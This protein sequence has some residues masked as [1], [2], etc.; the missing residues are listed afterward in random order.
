M[1]LEYRPY[2]CNVCGHK[3]K[4]QTNHEGPVLNYCKEC[5]WKRDFKGKEHSHSI[6]ALSGHTY[7][8][9]TFDGSVNEMKAPNTKPNTIDIQ[10]FIKAKECLNEEGKKKLLRALRLY[11]ELQDPVTEDAMDRPERNVV[12]KTFDTKADFDSYVNQRRGIEMTSKEQQAILNYREAKPTQRDRFFVKFE[13]TDD[14]GNNDTTVIKKLKEGNQFCWTAFS[15][16]ETAEEEGKP[17]GSDEE[18]SLDEAAPMAPAQA[19]PTTPSNVPQPPPE[20]AEDEEMTVDDPIRITKTIT[21]TDDTE[22]S[23]VLADFL[24]K[25]DL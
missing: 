18:P 8:V 17:E 20:P 19:T 25:L 15:K 4:I 11:K 2:V 12:A 13:T 7:R 1:K 6:P 9:F 3:D 23:N 22:G 16:H 5:S 21:F 24:Q 10:R 14:F